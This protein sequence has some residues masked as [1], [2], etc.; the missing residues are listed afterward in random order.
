MKLRSWFAGSLLALAATSCSPDPDPQLRLER[1]ADLK[2]MQKLLVQLTQLQ[3]SRQAA[4]QDVSADQIA[5]AM[6]PL[7]EVLGE[8]GKS[9]RDLSER[10]ATLT[11]EMRQWT[12]LLVASMSEKQNEQATA[13]GK[14]LEEL[15]RTI[16]E[17]D[18][19]HR[20]VEEL[21]STALTRTADQLEQFLKRL[22]NV[23]TDRSGQPAGAAPGNPPGPE[24]AQPA[25]SDPASGGPRSGGPETANGGQ[26]GEAGAAKSGAAKAGAA[27]D[28]PEQGQQAS[29][30]P[31]WAVAF[32]AIGAGIWLL[33]P[34][35]RRQVAIAPEMQ[36][37]AEPDLVEELAIPEPPA[38]V[39]AEIAALQE[40]QASTG[41]QPIDRS[42]EGDS[43]V[44]GALDVDAPDQP[45]A[46]DEPEV[47]EL[48]TA[49]ALLG[50]AI[51]RIKQS[52]GTLPDGLQQALAPVVQPQ[53]PSP[54]AAPEPIVEPVVEAPTPPS[55]PPQPELP[56]PA[57]A[58]AQLEQP[59]RPEP[60]PQADFELDDEL[61]VIDEDE[62]AEQDFREQQGA[63]VPHEV[64]PPPPVRP[65]VSEPTV[66]MPRPDS[67]TCRVP[68][69]DVAA[70]AGQV[71]DLLGD[72][73][74]V[75]VQPAPRVERRSD[76]LEVSFSLLP[77]LPAGERALLEQRLRDAAL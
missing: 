9:Q 3:T 40:Q 18:Q 43:L 59:E 29:M 31:L 72:D 70:A 53:P 7:R 55:D 23:S 16:A 48:W 22:D 65:S 35:R 10:Q 77:D 50:E 13:M 8:L 12:Q 67:I 46:T 19:R 20:Q 54:L 62:D 36:V 1:Q 56:E 66:R 76:A 73:P 25:T 33:L 21:M 15:E 71:L 44:D 4:P 42:I 61:F 64:P 5:T 34:R 17:Q 11:K 60:E 74:R 69:Q 6:S 51:G 68:A 58:A 41:D 30:W 28:D 38:P 52:G 63:T 75:L 32:L 45:Q 39:A 47:E 49:A 26:P 57:Q 27:G 2:V 37:P 14:R 24:A